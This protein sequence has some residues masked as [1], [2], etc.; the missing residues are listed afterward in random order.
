[1]ILR[2]SVQQFW[3]WPLRSE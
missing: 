3:P 1:M 2:F